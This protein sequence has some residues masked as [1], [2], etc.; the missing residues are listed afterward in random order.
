VTGEHRDIG[1]TMSSFDQAASANAKVKIVLVTGARRT[2]S[3]LLGSILGCMPSVVTVGEI[4]LVWHWGVV[5]NHRCGCG[6]RFLDCPFW[7]TVLGDAFGSGWPT[8]ARRM[9]QLRSQV[10]RLRHAPRL[11]FSRTQNRFFRDSIAQ[12]RQELSVLYAAVAKVSGCRTIVDTSKSP[13]HGLVLTG[14]PAFDLSILHLV[15]D[16]R[17]V[18]CSWQ[19][20]K[21]VDVES[22]VRLRRRPTVRAV[23]GWVSSN[24]LGEMLGRRAASYDLIQYEVLAT[25]TARTIDR[26]RRIMGVSDTMPMDDGAAFEMPIVHSVGGNAVQYERGRVHVRLDDRWRRDLSPVARALVTAGTLPWLQRYGYHERRGSSFG[27]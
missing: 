14:M 26:L 10:D 6:T 18:V 27:R 16:S 23:L 3:T 20:E 7:T 21:R 17:A 8:M 15:R 11:L 25:D 1:M 22:G 5:R 13:S 24:V 9:L 4:R 2:G 19:R 12:Y